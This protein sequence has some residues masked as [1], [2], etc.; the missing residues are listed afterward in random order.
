MKKK[1][2]IIILILGVEKYFAHFHLQS[3]LKM[4]KQPTYKACLNKANNFIC[5]NKSKSKMYLKSTVVY[6]KCSKNFSMLNYSMYYR[7]SVAHANTLLQ[8]YTLHEHYVLLEK[9]G[10]SKGYWRSTQVSSKYLQ[11]KG[12][13]YSVYGGVCSI[14]LG[15]LAF[16]MYTSLRI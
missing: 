5:K 3:E 16:S 4:I 10:E 13:L 7:L 14:K 12:Q 1:C 15:I 8:L 9:H 11:N 2:M 6:Y